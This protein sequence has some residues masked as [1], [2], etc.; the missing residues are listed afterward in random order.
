M[1]SPLYRAEHCRDLENGC[2][3]ITRLCTPSPEI[4]THQS[5]MAERYSK[6]TNAEELS[7][8]ALPNWPFRQLQPDGWRFTLLGCVPPAPLSAPLLSVS[9]YA[10]AQ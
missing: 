8:L 6:L 10:N 4:Q 7:A 3:A 2:C 9:G 1:P 5:R